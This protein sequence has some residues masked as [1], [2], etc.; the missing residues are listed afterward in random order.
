MVSPFADDND[1]INLN[2]IFQTTGSPDVYKLKDTKSGKFLT[3]TFGSLR[4]S[5]EEAD[6]D[7][8]KWK[9]IRQ[10]GGFYR[11][12]SLQDQKFISVSGNN[13]FDGTPFISRHRRRTALLRSV[14][15][16]G[17]I[18]I[19]YILNYSIKTLEIRLML[20]KC[21]S[22]MASHLL[23]LKKNCNH[24]ININYQSYDTKQITKLR[25]ISLV[26][27]CSATAYRAWPLPARLM[28]NI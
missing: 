21:V 9:F 17:Q 7:N 20:C 23:S 8:Q 22:V 14:L 27:S 19:P 18:R 10:T 28:A 4:L 2:F 26:Y 15:R 3:N 11:I 5:N 25:V 16:F 12:Q 1:E 6:S 13:T 24:F